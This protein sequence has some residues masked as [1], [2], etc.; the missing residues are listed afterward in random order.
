M[1]VGVEGASVMQGNKNGLCVQLETSVSLYMI[2]I[3]CMGHI[4][5]LAYKIVTIDTCVAKVEELIDKVYVYFSKS[6]KRNIKFQQFALEKSD[7]K[8]MLKHVE[9][10]WISMFKPIEGVFEQYKFLTGFLYQN[11]RDV[12]RAKDLLY[13]M[14]NLEI[15]LILYEM[16]PML[17]E[18]NK[19]INIAQERSIYIIDFISERK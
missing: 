7:G 3:H 10:R 2:P 17:F 19:L 9:N 13:H 5:N 4:L 11:R 18:M 15:L 8:R 1:C 6:S 12:D 14:I 16:I